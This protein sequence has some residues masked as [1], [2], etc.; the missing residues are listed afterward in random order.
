MIVIYV[1]QGDGCAVHSDQGVVDD[2][3]RSDVLQEVVLNCHQGH[4]LLKINENLTIG[5]KR[6]EKVEKLEIN[7]RWTLDI[8]VLNKIA[9]VILITIVSCI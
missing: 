8:I 3:L 5:D 6:V 4:S 1:F 2:F 9:I 7:L